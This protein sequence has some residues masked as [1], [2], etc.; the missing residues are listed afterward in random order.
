MKDAWFPRALHFPGLDFLEASKDVLSSTYTTCLYFFGG[1]ETG[2]SFKD[3]PISH[4]N[5][6]NRSP[7]NDGRWTN[8]LIAV[9]IL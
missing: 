1:G 4:S 9:N 3:E 5:T 6:S 8:I 7:Q 2:N